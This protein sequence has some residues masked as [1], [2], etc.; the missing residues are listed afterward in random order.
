MK[1]SI[2]TLHNSV[3]VLLPVEME[4][5]VVLFGVKTFKEQL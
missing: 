5:K 2:G 3:G 1:D 4:C